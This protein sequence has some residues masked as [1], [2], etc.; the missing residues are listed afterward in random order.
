[1]TPAP[2]P[3]LYLAVI[4]GRPGPPSLAS[5]LL[6]SVLAEPLPDNGKPVVRRGRKAAGQADNLTAGLPKEGRTGRRS[7]GSDWRSAYRRIPMRQFI[8]RF[9]V[10][11]LAAL[12]LI[13]SLI[14]ISEPTR[15]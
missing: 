15:L 12:A 8:S 11:R 6:L 13:L 3:A 2:P 10:R 7:S 14:H 1:M 5:R 9:I 4:S